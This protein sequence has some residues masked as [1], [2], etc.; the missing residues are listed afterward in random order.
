MTRLETQSAIDGVQNH[1]A[2]YAL[3]R[4]LPPWSFDENLAELVE[5]CPECGIDEVIVKVNTEE[6]SH[7]IPTIEWMKDYQ[8]MLFRT[9][10]AL[11]AIGVVFSINPWITLGHRDHGHECLKLFPDIDFI[12]G[13]DGSQSRSCACPLSDGWRR[14][15]AALWRLYAETQ[16]DIIWIED[17]FRLPNHGLV[18]YGCFCKN[19]MEQFQEK[20]GNPVTRQQLVE[21]LLAPGKPHPWRKI[22]LD[23][24][25]QSLVETAG[26]LEKVVHKISP[27]TRLGLMSGQAQN[28]SLEGRD[29]HRLAEAVAGPH[30]FISRPKM[31]AYSEHSLRDLYECA[32]HIRVSRH[33]LPAGVIEMTEVE[34][35]PFTYY[36]KSA[37]FTSLQMDLSF[38]MG[39][40]G[41]TL[42]LYDHSG[43]PMSVTPYMGQMLS[44]RKTFHNAIVERCLPGGVIN[45]VRILHHDRGSEHMVL[46]EDADYS[47]MTQ[48][49]YKWQ[50]LLEPLGFSITYDQSDVVAISGQTIRAFSDE[51]IRAFLSSGVIIDLSALEILIERGFEEL[52]GVSIVRQF[53]VSDNGASAAEEFCDTEFG[54][55]R[56][57]Y[58]KINGI[59]DNPTIAELKLNPDARKLSQLVDSDTEAH[60]PYLSIF[61][62]ALGGRVAVYP[63]NIN[64]M[65]DNVAFLSH[66]RQVQLYN[67]LK[68]LSRDKLPLFVE[69]GAYPLAFRSDYD[70]Y[71]IL[72]IF[73]LSLDNWPHAKIH[74]HAGDRKVSVIRI[75][76][77]TSKWSIRKSIDIHYENGN[78]DFTIDEP[79][80]FAQPMLI[81]IDWA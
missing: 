51:D 76:D 80:A 33:C 72:G 21:A 8:P 10:K 35:C 29:W 79:I 14:H 70:G 67:V 63:I 73:N 44:E 54:G 62:N 48:D 27:Q 81:S 25:G 59:G 18:K 58:L 42:N 1:K 5:L 36:S 15:T 38:A 40:H 16:P 3:R 41:V 77:E 74:L 47:D 9:R 30:T 19:H 49:G 53:A 61:E 34:N 28:H 45:G 23:W 4:T 13:H 6:F 11:N 65:G 46:G 69:G 32:R 60:Y 20:V 68:W 71:S 22:W 39:A 37:R 50:N 56:R 78:I 43:T 57:K 66:F 7:G 31:G 2:W 12:V 55:G 75:L 52:L 17:D 64:E 26:F 24:Q